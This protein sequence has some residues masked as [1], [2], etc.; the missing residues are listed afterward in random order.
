MKYT[1]IF[2]LLLSLLGTASVYGENTVS[3][4][5][6]SSNISFAAAVKKDG[7]W[8]AIDENGKM[9]I[10]VSYDK[11]AVSLSEKEMQ[12]MDLSGY[13]GRADLI[14]VSLK[15]ERGFYN[16]AGKEIVPVSYE[17]RS[18]WKEGKLAV[19]DKNKK[20][21]FYSADGTALTPAVYDSVSDFENGS[22][23]V[24]VN[25]KYGY[26]HADGKEIPPVYQEARFFSDGLAAVKAD[27]KWGVIDQ[28]GNYVVTPVYQ[29]TGPVYSDG[30][31]AVQNKEDKWGFINQS[32]DVVI[33]FIYKNV[34]PE[35]KEHITAVQERNKL[36]GFIDNT[37]KIL[38]EPQFKE[39]LT[40]FS[41]GLAGVRTVDGK[42]YAK[43]D[44]TIAFMA[45]YDRI[46]PFEN[47]I[48]EIRED[49]VKETPRRGFPISISIGW[50]HWFHRSHRYYS[51]FDWGW[52]FGFPLFQYYPYEDV[53]SSVRVKRG[54][55]DHD[56]KVIANISNDQVFPVTEKG[57][58]IYNKER[59]GWMDLTGKYTVHTIYRT[60]IPE[61]EADI[62]LAKDED[63]NWGLLSMTDGK[64][65]TSFMY[66]KL[67]YIGNGFTAYKE[68]NK[69][70]ILDK[71][72]HYI[73]DPVY[74]A[75]GSY[76]DGLIPVKNEKGWIYLDETGKEALTFTKRISDVTAFNHGRAAVKTDGKWGLIDKE[77]KFIV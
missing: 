20:I 66:D 1:K 71:N 46:F 57:I 44:G 68:N 11:A 4:E 73:T 70:G 52:G 18:I 48:A 23:I 69:W 5:P 54:Y 74:T 10:P 49:E 6:D 51:P 53:T 72:G 38:A 34:H 64:E 40:P 37:G 61:T 43:P 22:A 14:E 28:K 56:G 27:N 60:L 8:G 32:G 17:N 7:K 9:I 35:F 77:G 31:L 50:G 65:L 16:R 12:T 62:L 15:K 33:P 67:E 75:V 2:L 42:G 55:I 58:L 47:G 36:W 39:V 63:K 30:L 25:D 41:E 3:P 59:Y 76:G 19:K 13:P 45:D 24:K 21:R 26:V 29:S